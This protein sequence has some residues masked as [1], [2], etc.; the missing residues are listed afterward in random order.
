MKKQ[1]ITGIYLAAGKSKR[2]RRNKL[3][4]AIGNVPLGSLALSTA[5]QSELDNTI[6]VTDKTDWVPAEL[7]QS[8][9]WSHVICKESV[10]GQS[11]SLKCGLHAA[12]QLHAE[13]VM[14]ILADQPFISAQ[15]INQLIRTYKAQTT[16]SFV[17]ATH[18]GVT[19]PPILFSSSMYADL[20]QLQGDKGARYLIQQKSA[21]G[22]FVEFP[23]LWPFFDVDTQ[24]DYRAI[25]KAHSHR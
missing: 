25:L 19:C 22:S 13:A 4:P 10:K 16:A 9:R 2:F 6:V 12:Q 5:L 11:Y 3:L 17:A 7:F 18:Y 21:E 8:N 15:M 24:D 14:I 23:D 1:G 20:L